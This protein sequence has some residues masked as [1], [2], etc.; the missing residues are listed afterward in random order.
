MDFQLQSLLSLYVLPVV[1]MPPEIATT[2]WRSVF[3]KQHVKTLI[4]IDEARCICEWLLNSTV[5]S[6]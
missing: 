5:V 1:M 3:E 4:A 6:R 2:C